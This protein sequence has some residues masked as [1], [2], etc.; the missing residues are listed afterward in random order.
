V[1][2]TNVLMSA[3]FFAGTPARVLDA[4]REGKFSLV[5]SPLILEEYRRVTEELSS[6]YA[7]VDIGAVLDLLTV[8][9]EVVEDVALAMQ[10]C[11]DAEDDKFLA[12][13]AAASAVLVSG[14]KDLLAVDGALGVRVASPKAF[15][16][17]LD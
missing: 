6:K 7:G 2:D 11:R 10:V 4:W 17:L 14:D 12:C 8:L 13:A 1:I 3:I 5:V 15:L 9:A 16:E